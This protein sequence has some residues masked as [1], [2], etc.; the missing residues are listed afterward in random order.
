MQR[1]LAWREV[2]AVDV[3][4]VADVARRA[5]RALVRRGLPDV[6]GGPQQL[7]VRVADVEAG[8]GAAPEV[9]EDG[10][11]GQRVVGVPAHGASVHGVRPAV[12]GPAGTVRSVPTPCVHPH[13]RR[14]YTRVRYIG[15]IY[16]THAP[17]SPESTRRAGARHPRT[18]EGAAAPRLRAEEASRRDARLAVGDLLRLAVPGAAAPRARRRDRDR[19][20]RPSPRRCPP[21]ARSTA[22]SPRPGCAVRAKPT[23]RTR[24][25]YRLT[26]RGDA[27]LSQLLLDDDTAGDDERTFALE[28]RV[29][30]SP[31]P[32]R[33]ARAAAPPARRARRPPRPRPPHGAR[34]RRPLHRA[35][36]SSTAPSPPNETSNG[37]TRSSRPKAATTPNAPANPHQESLD[38]QGA[39][40]S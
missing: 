25:A 15:A 24:K 5:H 33:A 16:R 32:R 36:C 30:P 4:D 3:R 7:G 37:S 6:A 1:P 17:T 40:A 34:S 23:R 2:L 39:T 35:R 28:A 13:V 22:T 27:R 8:H 26:E 14:V 10:P 20:A 29:L 31:R 38:Q 9:A 12:P 21:P 11:S 18:A 19:R